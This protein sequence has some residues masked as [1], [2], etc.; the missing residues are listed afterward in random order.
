MKQ[1][2]YFSIKKAIDK[3]N[4]VKEEIKEIEKSLAILIK[5]T[6]RINNV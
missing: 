2:T 5:K 3:L 6:K 4:Q 1:T